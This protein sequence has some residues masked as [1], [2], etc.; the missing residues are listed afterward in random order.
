[1]V[2]TAKLGGRTQRGHRAADE[3]LVI[4]PS[5]S[6]LLAGCLMLA[7]CGTLNST[8]LTDASSSAETIPSASTSSPQS[9]AGP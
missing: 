1:M 9:K 3:F 2:M 7:G 5:R 6:V 4:R 8:D